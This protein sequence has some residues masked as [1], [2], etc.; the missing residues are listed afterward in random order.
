MSRKSKSFLFHF[1]QFAIWILGSKKF[2]SLKDEAFWKFVRQ[3][4]R[5][6]GSRPYLRHRFFIRLFRWTL[7]ETEIGGFPVW[8][9]VPSGWNGKRTVL[10]LHGGGNVNEML[11]IQWS[12]LMRLLWKTRVRAVIPQYPL[13]PDF[14]CLDAI[15][16][17]L[18][19]YQKLLAEVPADEIIFMGDSAGGALTLST[20]MECRERKLPLPRHLVMISPALEASSLDLESDV[21]AQEYERLDPVLSSKSFSAIL[22]AWRGNLPLKDWHVQPLYGNPENLPPMS[23][24]MGT[25]DVLHRGVKWFREKVESLNSE[26]LNA[27]IQL[28]YRE[29]P[30]MFH[31]W[32]LLPM[33]ESREAQEEIWK[34]VCEGT[35]PENQSV[36]SAAECECGSCG[37]SKRLE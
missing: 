9:A 14:T 11:P 34:I 28:N 19:L 6:Q 5:A 23:I 10:Y 16:Q 29:F 20:G 35:H 25:H 15:E 24:F 26:N 32:A 37:E 33:P 21:E 1:A 8:F 31:C 3:N 18:A 12:F 36:K 13:A 17:I 2:Y 27:K 30:E 4:R 22:E 7:T